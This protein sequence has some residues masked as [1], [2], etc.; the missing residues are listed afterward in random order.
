MD[1]NTISITQLKMNPAAAIAQA[2]DYPLEVISRGK[3]QAYLVGKK[4]FE[5]IVDY[6]E[7][8]EDLKAVKDLKSEY[9]KGR[10]VEELMSELG[11]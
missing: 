4:L 5:N 11:I 1:N 9:P 3:S 7:D 8:Q 6:L 2:S 10:P